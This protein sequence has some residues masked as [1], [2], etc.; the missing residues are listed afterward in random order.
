[1]TVLGLDHVQ[2]A[3]APGMED[4]C[5]RFWT[6]LGFAEVEKP[7]ALAGRGGLWLEGGTA[8]LHLGLQEPLQA[9][10]KA[11]PA[12]AVSDLDELRE[13]LSRL[14]VPVTEERPFDGRRRF[15]CDDPAGNRI[16]FIE[17]APP[18]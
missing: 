15:F 2:L 9:A 6:A 1:M 4:T 12:F 11:H 8:R 10:R 17:G 14:D 3:I 7:G 5:R 13:R 16:E 18:A